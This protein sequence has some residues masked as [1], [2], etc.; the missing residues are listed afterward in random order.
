MATLQPDLTVLSSVKL[1][2]ARNRCRYVSSHFP[3]G[4]TWMA[5]DTKHGERWDG[6]PDIWSGTSQDDVLLHPTVQAVMI[7]C[8][9]REA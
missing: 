6:P 1:D 3:M 8:E 4:A 5:R 2:D 9:A 7:W